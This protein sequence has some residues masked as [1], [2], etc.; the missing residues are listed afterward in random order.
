MDEESRRRFLRFLSASPLLAFPGYLHGQAGGTLGNPA[1]AI[2]V[3]DFEEAARRVL[4]PAHWGY[5]ATGVDDDATLKANVA[6]Y[7]QIE[8]RPRRLIDSTR[9]DLGVEIFGQS[10]ETPI[11]ICPIGNQKAFHPEAELATARAARARRTNQILSSVTSYPVEEVSTALGRP[12]WFQLYMPRKWDDTVKL[13]RRVEAA[14]CPVLVWTIDLLAGRN[15]ET[16]ERFRRLDTRDCTAC[17]LTAKGGVRHRPM[18]DGLTNEEYNPPEATWEYVDRLRKLT[19]MRLVLKGI[20]TAEDAR[21]CREHGVD[22][23]HVSNHGGRAA[24]TGRATVECLPE[25]VQ[26][27]GALPVIVDGGIRRGSDIF[28]AL[29]LGARA[30]GIGRPYI[31]GLSAFGQ[32]G[33]E[34]VLELLRAELTLTMRQAGT[35]SI[36]QIG[37]SSVITQA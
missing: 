15:T 12:P 21:L 16:A 3:M 1:D 37:K 29:A 30:V 32:P 36:G 13:V 17:H 10:W 23:I 11:M 31:W 28:K 4:P 5:L 22:A 27:A 20:E 7:R 24:E 6:G 14:G 19:K 34:R 35:P 26:A 25:V 33:V 2:N 18:F 9:T 8:I